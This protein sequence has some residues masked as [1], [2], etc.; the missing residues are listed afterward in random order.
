MNPNQSQLDPQAVALSKAIRH[1]E[2]GGDPNA[3]GSSGEYGAYQWEP[4]SWDA[5]SQRAGIN[6]PLHESSLEQQNQVAYTQ[7]KAWK[8]QGYN[9]GQIASMWNAGEGKPNAYLEGNA[10]VN[11]EGVSYDTAEYARKVAEAYHQFNGGASYPAP[12]SQA[13]SDTSTGYPAPQA[14][15]TTAGPD[16]TA[17]P[18]ETFMGDLSQGDFMGAAKT[19][20]EGLVNAAFP[21]IDDVGADIQ[22]K[23]NK[24]LLQQAA[25]LGLSALWFAP[26]LDA[27]A[28]EAAAALEG[29]G[30]LGKIAHGALS[31][32]GI[33]AA[34]GGLQSLSQGGNV[35][36]GAATGALGGGVLGGAFGTLG[37]F[38]NNMPN[39]LTQGAL[40]LDSDTAQYALDTK[41]MGSVDSLLK[42]STNERGVIGQ[43]ISDVLEHDYLG[44]KGNGTDAATLA[45]QSFQH[46][47]VTADDIMENASS[48]LGKPYQSLLD[49]FMSGDATLADKNALKSALDKRVQR[50]YKSAGM[51]NF[52]PA[53]LDMGAAFAGALRDE[54]KSVAPETVPLFEKY[55]KEMN[56]YKALLKLSKKPHRNLIGLRDL[57]AIAA[58]GAGGS[59]A[60]GPLVGLPAAA[61][62]FGAERLGS[63]AG[64]QFAL[65]K[66]LQKLSPAASAAGNAG[67]IGTS[68]LLGAQ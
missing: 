25:D 13:Q 63:S 15:T 26:G 28:P 68:R 44:N 32:A 47:S 33:G 11:K 43:K 52:T 1:V 29:S 2:S 4:G 37:G 14:P 9:P 67:L 36:K 65:A 27:L 48:L 18:Q 51:G 12:G 40:K 17:Q 60:G 16:Q 58:A 64:G 59:V 20:A 6:V 5:M 50:V 38:L 24:N 22:G 19:G 55:Q 53:T 35:L 49:K 46:G 23:S 21:I 31:G 10:G 61:L 41:K 34:A 39:R 7:I 66:G 3:K 30:F 57:W 54:V 8:D 56:L 42:Q 45:A 62:G